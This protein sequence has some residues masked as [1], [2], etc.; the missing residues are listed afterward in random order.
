[1]GAA[2]PF[3]K[4]RFRGGPAAK[5]DA[6]LR[7]RGHG[8]GSKVARRDLRARYTGGAPCV[9]DAR[10]II[11]NHDRL[12][13]IRAKL[14]KQFHFYDVV[15]AA[16]AIGAH[17]KLRK[18]KPQMIRDPSLCRLP[19][20]FWSS[21]NEYN[22]VAL[23][24]GCKKFDNVIERHIVVRFRKERIPV[25]RLFLNMVQSV[26][27][28]RQRAVNVK[29][30]AFHFLASHF[31]RCFEGG[32]G[33]FFIKLFAPDIAAQVAVSGFA[34]SLCRRFDL[35]FSRHLRIPYPTMK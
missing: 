26:R 23:F 28:I 2:N 33:F 27:A 34:D 24:D 4:I 25:F 13:P 8:G 30:K 29:N 14:R 19:C 35:F 5:R 16:V 18:A 17:V 32:A 3:L 9:D 10:S 21:R 6:T 22:R 15:V 12:E 31:L 20:A 11:K 1:M 7:A